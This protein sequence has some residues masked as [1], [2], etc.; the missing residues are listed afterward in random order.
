[1]NFTDEQLRTIEE[2]LEFALSRRLSEF[3]RTRTAGNLTIR[4]QAV[5]WAKQA[6]NVSAVLDQVRAQLQ[7][8]S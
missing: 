4:R 1:M 6:R 3:E 8:V 2:A 5:K 7:K